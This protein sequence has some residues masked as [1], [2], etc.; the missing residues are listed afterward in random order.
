MQLGGP[1]IRGRLGAAA[2]LLLAPGA[3]GAATPRW[4]VDLSGLLYGEKARATVVEPMVRVARLF[5][6]GQ[7]LSATLGFDA[8]TGASPTGGIPTTTIQ[9]TTTPSGRSQST[10]VGTVPTNP[11]KDMRGSLDVAWTK[12]F[13]RG[14]T[15]TL[16]T[17]LSR[18]KDY[19]SVGANGKVS[20]DFM[21]RLAT[22]SLGAGYN[23]DAVSPTGG[24]HAPLSDA[25]VVVS[26]DPNPKQVAT[27]VAGL[28]R[29]LSRRWLAAVDVS[30]TYEHGYLTEPYKVISTVDG[31]SGDPVNEVTEGRPDTRGRWSVTASSVYH[32]ETDVFYASDRFYWDDWG[33]RSNTVDVRYR[34]ELKEHR[35]IEPHA[36]YYMQTRANFFESFLV[37]GEPLPEF[38]SADY[39]LG[40]L[41]ALTLGATFGW[42]PK[43][44]PGEWRLRG[45]YMYRTGTGN[46]SEGIGNQ[47]V[48]DLFPPFGSFSLSVLYSVQ[49]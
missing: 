21:Q 43:E 45:E 25:S 20:L 6:N 44:R 15:T 39:R 41:N 28:S 33:V 8:V 24:T 2:A 26:T 16:G 7:A 13:A 38:V 30:R 35:Y 19:R 12:P 22:V 29:V 9:T 37:D 27:F 17:H 23:D 48:T 5:P 47:Q 3:A 42:R 34:R 1:G 10:P 36:R 4:Q 49:F 31:V 46:P 18:E 11:F 40:A 14:L 32:L